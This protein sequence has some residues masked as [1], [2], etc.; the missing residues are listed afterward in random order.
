[1]IR[2][3]DL[4]PSLSDAS[5]ESAVPKSLII[6]WFQFCSV[7]SKGKSGQSDCMADSTLL[8]IEARQL[9]GTTD[10]RGTT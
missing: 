3:A 1:M 2:P 7:R 10:N 8:I 6:V 5:F 9:I 4:Q